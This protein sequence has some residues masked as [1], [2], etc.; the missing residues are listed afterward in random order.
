MGYLVRASTRVG[1]RGRRLATIRGVGRD[2]YVQFESPGRLLVY[3]D[4]RLV[5]LSHRINDVWEVEFYLLTGRGYER[6]LAETR[7]FT[8]L[9]PDEARDMVYISKFLEIRYYYLLHERE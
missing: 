4:G 5:A 1:P 2:M 7:F 6:S 9:P 8:G 3:R